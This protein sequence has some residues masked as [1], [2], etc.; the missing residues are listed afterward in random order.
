MTNENAE[1]PWLSP[2]ITNSHDPD[3]IVELVNE[4]TCEGMEG[5]EFSSEMLAEQYAYYAADDAGYGLNEDNLYAHLEFLQE[6]GGRFDF[7]KALAWAIKL[8][9]FDPNAD[10]TDCTPTAEALAQST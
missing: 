10:I 6:Y 3:V 8:A 1:T 2:A 9:A 5:I 7:S 4:G